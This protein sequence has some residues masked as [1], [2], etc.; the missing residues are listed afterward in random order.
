M[1][2][3]ELSQ[4]RISR[5]GEFVGSDRASVR[6]S[7]AARL[8]AGDHLHHVHFKSHRRVRYGGDRDRLVAFPDTAH[9]GM[10][11]DLE[12]SAWTPRSSTAHEELDVVADA[13]S[14]SRV[15]E[16]PVSG[17][18]CCLA[19]TVLL[20]VVRVAR[21]RTLRFGS[22][23]DR[24][25]DAFSRSRAGEQVRC[26][27]VRATRERWRRASQRVTGRRSGSCSTARHRA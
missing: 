18:H 27:R 23:R 3:W 26:P 25:C 8:K 4:F 5:C 21:C 9:D 11:V 7:V 19:R 16:Y 13:T 12:R 6:P 1:G 10:Q 14:H 17:Y 20:L 22:S 24:S 15:A 2:S